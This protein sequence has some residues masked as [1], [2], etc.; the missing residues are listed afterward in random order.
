M[1]F[2]VPKRG[3]ALKRFTPGWDR[4]EPE[5]PVIVLLPERFGWPVI[6]GSLFSRAA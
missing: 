2:M 5:F 6:R 3:T 1:P 4:A